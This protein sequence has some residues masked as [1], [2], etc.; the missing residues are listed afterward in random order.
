M[1]EDLLIGYGKRG[2]IKIPSVTERARESK[3]PRKKKG[4]I[5]S[6]AQ[7]IGQSGKERKSSKVCCTSV[8]VSSIAKGIDPCIKHMLYM[9]MVPWYTYFVAT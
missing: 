8:I 1:L 6:T 9:K 7:S 4:C 2:E 5:H 3:R